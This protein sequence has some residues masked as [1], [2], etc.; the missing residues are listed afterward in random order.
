[1]SQPRLAIAQLSLLL[2]LWVPLACEVAKP[3]TEARRPEALFLKSRVVLRGHWGTVGAL[4][5]TPDGRTLIVGSGSRSSLYSRGDLAMWDVQTGR[6]LRYGKVWARY[7]AFAISPNGKRLIAMDR[8]HIDIWDLGSFRRVRKIGKGGWRGMSL[9]PDGKS[10]ALV[11]LEGLYRKPGIE[12]IDLE[13]GEKTRTLGGYY[14]AVAF[15]PDGKSLAAGEDIQFA[16]DDLLRGEGTVYLWDTTT[17]KRRVWADPAKP[18]GVCERSSTDVV[19]FSP[20]GKRLLTIA[21]RTRIWDVEKQRVQ[22]SP[23]AHPRAAAFSPDGR[24]LATVHD[25]LAIWDIRTA[26]RLAAATAHQ[27][28]IWSVAFSPDGKLLATGG[29]DD[30]TVVLWDVHLPVTQPRTGPSNSSD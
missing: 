4:I 20:D 17:W 29:N 21:H 14:S 25:K 3:D 28:S 6:R 12:I 2:S 1:M 16:G 22:S 26:R 7:D 27:R 5:F 11:I 15:S 30:K 13:T 10:V 8:Y 24:A 9:S 19:L 18:R 23:A